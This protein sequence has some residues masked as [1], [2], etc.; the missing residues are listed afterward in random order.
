MQVLENAVRMMKAPADEGARNR[1]DSGDIPVTDFPELDFGDPESLD[2]PDAPVPPAVPLIRSRTRPMFAEDPPTGPVASGPVFPG[3]RAVPEDAPHKQERPQFGPLLTWMGAAASIALIVGVSVWTYK[4]G[5]RDAMDV[6]IIAAMEG[7]ARIA[8]DEPG[9]TQMPHQ[10]LSVNSVLEGGGVAD[11][12]SSVTVA[13]SGQGVTD[14]DAAQGQLATIAA[15]RKPVTRP[16]VEEEL[17]NENLATVLLLQELEPLPAEAGGNAADEATA[18]MPAGEPLVAATAEIVDASPTEAEVATA[19]AEA[20]AIATPD[21]GT[22]GTAEQVDANPALAVDQDAVQPAEAM[23]LAALGPTPPLGEGSAY[24]P[25]VLI[26]PKARPADLAPQM[27]AAIDAALA[28]VLTQATAETAA[29]TPAPAATPTVVAKTEDLSTIPLP[30]G[31]RLIQLGAFD[32]EAVARRQWDQISGR[33]GD[34]LGGKDYYVQKIDRSG[35]TFYRLRVA[36][37]ANKQETL[38]ACAAI[39]ARGLPCM[40]AINR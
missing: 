17:L 40:P 29:P 21:P 24:A 4:L 35:R 33:H 30:E 6:P 18:A 26:Q 14:E 22:D 8:P 36:G 25:A 31:T 23:V 34:L 15:A 13:A 9:G 32:S 1:M 10:G 2:P 12:A 3:D 20:V 39:T 19:V 5:Q 7:P 28:S 37:Y 16:E 27:A 38:A 11:V